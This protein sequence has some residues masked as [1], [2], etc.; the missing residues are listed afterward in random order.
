MAETLGGGGKG[1]G[2]KKRGE[3]EEPKA[4]PNF[5][6]DE[7]RAI[8]ERFTNLGNDFDSAAGEYRSDV[9]ALYEEAVGTLG[10]TRRIWGLEFKR[11]RAEQKRLKREN[12]LE[13]DEKEM[14]DNIRDA[15]GDFAETPLGAAALH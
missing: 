15:L 2:R 12:E 9:K 1:R 8:F 6:G 13:K 7:A 14:L 5:N 3:G 4:R 11:V 10:G